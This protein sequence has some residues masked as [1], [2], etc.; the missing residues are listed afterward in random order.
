MVL[1]IWRS[2]N[3]KI[4]NI[5]M[6]M[7]F[8]CDKIWRKAKDQKHKIPYRSFHWM[9]GE[10]AIRGRHGEGFR[11]SLR[12]FSLGWLVRWLFLSLLL[13]KLT[14]ILYT[15]FHIY[16]I[17]HILFLKRVTYLTISVGELFS[18]QSEMIFSE[19]CNDPYEAE[20]FYCVISTQTPV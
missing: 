12:F 20:I 11:I 19:N 7:Q 8:T 4:N 17:I 2:R 14:N 9:E 5:L 18:L 3:A 6:E 15:P 10:E 1:F 13:F 16:S